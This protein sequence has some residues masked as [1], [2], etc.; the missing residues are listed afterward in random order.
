MKISNPVLISRSDE[1]RHCIPISVLS[2]TPSPISPISALSRTTHSGNPPDTLAPTSPLRFHPVLPSGEVSPVRVTPREPSPPRNP[3]LDFPLPPLPVEIIVEED[4]NVDFNLDPQIS[5]ESEFVVPTVLK[6]PPP[7][8][9]PSND[10]AP[11]E[12]LSPNSPNTSFVHQADPNLE[13]LPIREKSPAMDQEPQSRF[14]VY[15]NS[16]AAYS[17]SSANTIDSPASACFSSTNGDS[18]V[19]DSP[20]ELP[21]PYGSEIAEEDSADHRS[22]PINDS[23]QDLAFGGLRIDTGDSRRNAACFGFPAFQGYSLPEEENSSQAT[24]RK[25]ATLQEASRATFGPSAEGK[26]L[27]SL[28][29][30]GQGLSALDELLNELGYLGDSIL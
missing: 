17:P 9:R 22:L 29:E 26:F 11:S 2:R 19:P 20:Y 24:L 28:S 6:P 18:S 23:D 5:Q 10:A 25:T 16:T 1:G 30:S 7:R 3:A 15:S 4:E 8:K 12:C 21:T 27:Q 14:S 13:P